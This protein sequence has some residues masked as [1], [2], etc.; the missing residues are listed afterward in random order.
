MPFKHNKKRDT[1]LVYEFLVRRLGTTLVEK[2]PD[3]Y[4]K[5][6]EIF[7]RYFSEGTPLAEEK[8][9]FDVII[10]TR[11]ASSTV[12]AGLISEV[13]ERARKLDRKKIE[14]KKSNLIKEVHLAFGKDFFDVHRIPDYRLFAAIQMLLESA[15][16]SRSLSE[17]RDRLTIEDG[18]IRY[19]TSTPKQQP[20]S[21]GQKVDS[22][23]ASLALKKFE[24]R[25]SGT[26]D[27]NQKRI[28]RRFMHYSVSGNS[29]RFSRELEE[30]RQEMKTIL[31]VAST[32][33]C[34]RKDPE[35]KK[36]LDESRRDLLAMDFSQN[37]EKSTERLLM[38]RKLA[39]ELLSDE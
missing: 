1:G 13:K 21:A 39:Q 38:F 32:E 11:G 30:E 34:F 3:S 28:L 8:Q 26:L 15:G 10:S 7:R 23:V 12:A 29:E 36:K 6:L 35:M 5:T 27:E 2:D 20:V 14:I 18:L 24:E 25:Y 22:F 9:L 37:F 19:M 17:S 16:S 33:E 31:E 4:R